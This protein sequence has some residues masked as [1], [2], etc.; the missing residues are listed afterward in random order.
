MEKSRRNLLIF[1]GEGFGVVGGGTEVRLPENCRFWQFSCTDTAQLF[2][3]YG[4]PNPIGPIQTI[5]IGGGVSPI[6]VY[7]GW[8]AK[9]VLTGAP[10]QTIMVWWTW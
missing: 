3:H 8:D 9:L 6:M 2:I 5:P 7:P 1:P 10:T 4:Q